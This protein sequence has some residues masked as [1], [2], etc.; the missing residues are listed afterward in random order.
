MSGMT[1][2]TT[3]VGMTVLILDQWGGAEK[4]TEI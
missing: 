3:G 1:P 4:I 2:M